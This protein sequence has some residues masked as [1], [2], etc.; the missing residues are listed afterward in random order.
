MN[1]V[2]YVHFEGW[3]YISTISAYSLHFQIL[4]ST[5]ATPVPTMVSVMMESTALSATAQ[6]ASS[7]HA[8]KQVIFKSDFV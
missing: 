2:A 6:L 1:A 8:V 5:S 3:P 4:M 7:G